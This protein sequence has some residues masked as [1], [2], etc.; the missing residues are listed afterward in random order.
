VVSSQRPTVSGAYVAFSCAILIW[1]WVEITFLSGLITGPRTAPCPAGCTGWSRVGCAINAILYHELVLLALAAMIVA[2]TWNG[3]NQ[4][5][6]MTFLVLWTMRLSA[7]V[8][9]FLG[10]PILNDEFLP[11]RLGYLKSFFARGPLNH[12]F[13]VAVT[14]STVVAAW[15]V[16]HAASAAS[17]FETTEFLLL[18]TLL[19]LAVLEH[20]F[21]VVPLPVTALWDWGVGTSR[22]GKPAPGAPTDRVAVSRVY[23]APRR[24]ADWPYD[25][26]QHELAADA[27][28]MP[29]RRPAAD[30]NHASGRDYP[31]PTVPVTGSTGVLRHPLLATI[32]RHP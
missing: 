21:M 13:P 6:A 18:A 12:L 2:A 1:G 27:F 29:S 30:V 9:L 10:V 14:I 3:S 20:W 17:A 31:V 28:D 4:V 16:V 23:G 32:W 19:G 22:F 8:N 5:A 25:D 26:V 15:W 11:E 24:G 7:K